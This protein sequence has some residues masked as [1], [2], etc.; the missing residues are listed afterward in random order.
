MEKDDQT[1]EMEGAE[2]A[3]DLELG[4]SDETEE[5]P[6]GKTEDKPEDPKSDPL[7]DI[8]DEEARN[9]AKA[10]RAKARRAKEKPEAHK[11]EGEFLS[12]KDFYKSNERKAIKSVLEV[13][14][15]AS[16]EVKADKAYIADNWKGIRELYSNR[17]GKETPDDVLEDINDAIALYKLKNPPKEED[18]SAEELQKVTGK[19][20]GGGDAPKTEKPLPPGFNLPVQPDSWYDDTLKALKIQAASAREYFEKW[21]AAEEELKS[22]TLEV[23]DLENRLRDAR[24]LKKEL[25]E[26]RKVLR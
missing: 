3:L 1:P 17:K 20:T 19:G 12:K 6:E 13:P 15:D 7:D 22:L 21:T 18:D 26:I 10:D 8:K 25:A 14:E 5:E 2:E 23:A 24:D 4:D 11:A 9:Q 16:D